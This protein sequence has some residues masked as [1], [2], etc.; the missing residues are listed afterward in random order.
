MLTDVFVCFF[1]ENN[2]YSVCG[3]GG[4]GSYCFDSGFICRSEIKALVS[5]F[6]RIMRFGNWEWC[7]CLMLCR[8]GAGDWDFSL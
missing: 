3:F 5:K 6:Q 8:H 2:Y 4:F 1:T 7:G